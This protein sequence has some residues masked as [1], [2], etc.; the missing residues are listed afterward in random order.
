L[1][2]IKTPAQFRKAAKQIRQSRKNLVKPRG[3]SGKNPK[4]N[5]NKVTT[6]QFWD[7]AAEKVAQKK[8][9]AEEARIL[10]PLRKDMKEESSG[11]LKK[12]LEPQPEDF[13]DLLRNIRALARRE[14]KKVIL[15]IPMISGNGIHLG[16]Y[17]ANVWG[18]TEDWELRNIC[19]N[20]TG[21]IKLRMDALPKSAHHVL[22]V[23][24]ENGAKSAASRYKQRLY[25]EVS[26]EKP[27]AS[28]EESEANA[29]QTARVIDIAAA[30]ACRE[31]APQDIS[32]ALMKR[33]NSLREALEKNGGGK[34]ELNTDKYLLESLY[35]IRD[36]AR[37]HGPVKVQVSV[38]VLKD[39]PPLDYRLTITGDENNRQI[40]HY[41]GDYALARR[42]TFSQFERKLLSATGTSPQP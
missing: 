7:V 37:E 36:L 14:D 42:E 23:L 13:T 3:P 5:H 9:A 10:A 38:T 19:A 33:M 18:H 11:E 12:I 8:A 6:D 25:F 17:N 21:E 39:W 27:V 2:D 1:A 41:S 16:L 29:Q 15:S 40:A 30:R 4:Q 31:A 20:Y 34:L 28:H 35:L 26:E 32:A 22:K 24:E